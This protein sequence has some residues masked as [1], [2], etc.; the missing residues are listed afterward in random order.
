MR[1]TGDASSGATP[2]P[3]IESGRQWPFRTS[4]CA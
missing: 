2:S 3:V 1:P 4:R